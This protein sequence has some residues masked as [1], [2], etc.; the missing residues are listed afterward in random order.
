IVEND[1]AQRRVLEEMIRRAGCNPLPA[2]SGAQ[3]LDML[4]APLGSTIELAL[5][6]LTLPGADGAGL[7]DE[8]RARRPGLPVI[9]QAAQGSIQSIFEAM[10]AGASDF[11]EKP[12]SLERLQVSIKILLK[13]SALTEQV[14]RLNKKVSGALTFDDL[15]ASSPAMAN[16]LRLGK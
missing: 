12:V 14:K 15:I 8:L 16:V 10:Q 3:A 6:D 7:V 11:V 1:P 4:L 2:E 9:T 13:L 5:V